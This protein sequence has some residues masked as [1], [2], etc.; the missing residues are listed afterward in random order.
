M[1]TQKINKNPLMITVHD[2]GFDYRLRIEEIDDEMILNGK[3]VFEHFSSRGIIKYG[4]YDDDIWTIS[5][6]VR[7]KK[8]NLTFSQASF[9][10]NVRNI[11]GQ[12]YEFVRN[13]LRTFCVIKL[14][15]GTA[16]A[17]I[18]KA[19]NAV[20]GFL[21]SGKVPESIEALINLENFLLL[22]PGEPLSKLELLQEIAQN[23]EDIERNSDKDNKRIM[24]GYTSYLM[25]DKLLKNFWAGATDSEKCV[26]F[27]V[28]FWWNVTGILPLRP[29]C[30]V[31]TPRDCLRVHNGKKYLLIRRTKLKKKVGSSYNLLEDYEVCEYR[32]TDQ[33][34]EEIAK[35]IEMTRGSYQS[36]IDVLFSKAAQFSGLNIVVANDNHYTYANLTQ[37]LQAFYKNVIASKYE[38]T[39]IEKSECLLDGEIERI[40]LGDSRVFSMINLFL[41]GNSAVVCKVLAGH[42]WINMGDHYY[43]N[44]KSFLDTLSFSVYRTEASNTYSYWKRGLVKSTYVPVPGGY[45]SS[46]A[47][48]KEDFSP[49][50]RAVDKQGHIGAC[51]VCRCFVPSLSEAAQLLA[52]SKESN[53]RMFYIVKAEVEAVHKGTGT[54]ESLDAKIKQLQNGT[55]QQVYYAVMYQ[56]LRGEEYI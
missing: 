41:T 33:M 45:C 6:E 24:A 44:L 23:E 34:Y 46:E 14:Q 9:D 26:Y 32:I 47:V 43:S 17:S 27:P 48:L 28:W 16:L 12:T 56:Y 21:D 2:D 36:D 25:F 50:A 15:Q 38:L 37:C 29:T 30:I 10:M 52:S 55:Q 22:L 11:I 18:P 1:E 31:L 42:D 5:N 51:K 8:I 53:D 20:R 49:C 7:T 35:Y 19:I 39:V 4:E 54:E 3:Q 13:A 40:S